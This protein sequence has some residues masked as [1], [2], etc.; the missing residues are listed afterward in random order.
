[1]TRQDALRLILSS[2]DKPKVKYRLALGVEIGRPAIL[3]TCD[4]VGDKIQG[5]VI[6]TSSVVAA[7]A[8]TGFIET[9]NTIYVPMHAKKAG[10]PFFVLS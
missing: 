8:I 3:C 7:S 10:R 9:L 6:R 2:N 4:T 1:M 5:D